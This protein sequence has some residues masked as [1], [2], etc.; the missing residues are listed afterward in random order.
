MAPRNAKIIVVGGGVAG[1]MA[2]LAAAEGGAETILVTRMPSR[3]SAS[4][5]ERFFNAALDTKG[6]GDAP[7]LHAQDALAFGSKL[8]SPAPVLAMCAA[9]PMLAR[10]FDRMGAAFRRSPEGLIDL[11]LAPG[12]SK[13]RAVTASSGAGHQI[14][15][16]LDAQLRRQ[17]A[18]ERIRLLENWEFLSLVLDDDGRC[19]GAV[20][21]DTANMEI[22]AF[23][24]D[25]VIL[26]S[27]GCAGLWGR[28]SLKPA[29]DGGAIAVCR[30]QGATLVNMDFVQVEVP[31]SADEG[32]E[33]E[34]PPPP[35]VERT[36]G[37]FK[38]DAQHATTVPGLFAAG[39]AA[40]LYHGAKALPGDGL[41]AAAFGG[42]TAGRAALAAVR[43]MGPAEISSSLLD[44][45]KNREEDLNAHFAQQ[46]GEENA[47]LIARELA[48]TLASAVFVEREKRTLTAAAE[49]IAALEDRFTRAALLDRNE[50]GNGELFAMRRVHGGLALAREIVAAA[51]ARL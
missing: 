1:G 11:S 32:D 51:V 30:E 47:H 31:A 19:R 25:A 15:A 6:E 7:A 8:A 2:A 14:A 37:G 5:T 35:R 44:A 46:Q 39:S 38:I 49:R 20:A 40:C 36:L 24:A 26:C 10:L 29:A 17:A 22:R 34:P 9:A 4:P 27:G 50:W 3:R 28:A 42:M 41:S 16:V 33:A 48:E 13:R 21:C 45:A 43:A 18:V 12:A 23:P